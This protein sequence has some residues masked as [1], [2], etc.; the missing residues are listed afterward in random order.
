MKRFTALPL[1]AAL[2]LAAGAPALAAPAAA[3][4]DQ[5]ATQVQA[6]QAWI[7]LLPGDLPAGGYVTLHNRGDAP[8][9]LTGASSPDYKQVMLHVSTLR[10]GMSHMSKVARLALPPH[11]TVKLSPGGYHLMLMHAKR[12]VKVGD[13]VPVTLEFADGS[14]LEV[15]FQARPATAH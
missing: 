4:A 1:M 3:G 9:A 12:P 2:A 10:N 15:S 13:T 11:A 5:P 14:R 7:R 6:S 8:R